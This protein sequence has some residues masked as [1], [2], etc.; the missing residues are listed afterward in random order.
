MIINVYD[1]L[2]R[3]KFMVLIKIICVDYDMIENKGNI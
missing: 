2:L 3:K 1:F